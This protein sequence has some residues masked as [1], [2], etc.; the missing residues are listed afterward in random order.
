MDADLRTLAERLGQM[1]P[2]DFCAGAVMELQRESGIFERGDCPVCDGT[3]HRLPTEAELRAA[4]F[5]AGWTVLVAR[6][7]EEDFVSLEICRPSEQRDVSAVLGEAAP[8]DLVLLALLRALEVCR[9]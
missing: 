3:G 7:I 9:G 6:R 8:G 2:C 1:K 4:I 5:E